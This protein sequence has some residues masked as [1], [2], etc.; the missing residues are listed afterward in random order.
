MRQATG[1]TTHACCGIG[2][3]VG[4]G[5]SFGVGI[6]VN[7]IVVFHFID[8]RKGLLHLLYEFIKF[9]KMGVYADGICRKFGLECHT[10][11][12]KFGALNTCV[13]CLVQQ[14]AW[15]WLGHGFCF[16]VGTTEK[17]GSVV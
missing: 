12:L 11:C 15:V 2:G 16:H 14:A 3:G 5:V 7:N 4:V 17:I 1:G 6:R 9:G 13:F 10:P 8:C